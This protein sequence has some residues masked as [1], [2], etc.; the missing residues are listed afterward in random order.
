MRILVTGAS[1]RLGSYL[2]DRL[3]DGPH[4]VLAWSGATR[5]HRGGIRLRP[6]DLTDESEVADEFI[7]QPKPAARGRAEAPAA[8]DFSYDV[9]PG[10]AAVLSIRH[11]SG[12]LSGCRASA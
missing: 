1:G 8:L 7:A 3:I 2:V 4:E 5:G 12:A 11:P 9:A 6:V 10:E